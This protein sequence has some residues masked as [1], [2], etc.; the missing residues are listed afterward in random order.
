MTKY[1]ALVLVY[2][3]VNMK[4]RNGRLT[5][6]VCTWWRQ[7]A[8]LVDSAKQKMSSCT[9]LATYDN[10]AQTS[11]ADV[12]V[13]QIHQSRYQGLLREPWDFTRLRQ[14]CRPEYCG[15]E[16]MSSPEAAG[17]H[18]LTLSRDPRLPAVCHG[19]NFD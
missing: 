16:Y 17:T 7:R 6:T 10:P 2:T 19:H 9:T 11:F 14:G 18:G 13:A 5:G 1:I 8:L 3:E 4:R 12:L 15:S